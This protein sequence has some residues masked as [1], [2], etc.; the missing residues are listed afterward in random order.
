MKRELLIVGL[1]F[2]FLVSSLSGCFEQKDDGGTTDQNGEASFTYKGENARFGFLGVYPDYKNEFDYEEMAKI[3]VGWIRVIWGDS[4]FVWGNIEKT[5]GT[6]DFSL[7]DEFVKEMQNYGFNIF[8]VIWPYAQWDQQNCYNESCLVNENDVFI[9]RLGISRCK[10]CNE[11]AYLNFI[12]TMVERYDDDDI[13][14]MPGLKYPIKYYEFLNEPTL[15]ID[16]EEKKDATEMHF[17]GTS[18]EFVEFMNITYDAMKEVYPDVKIV[19]AGINSLED[20]YLTLDFWKVVYEKHS[21]FDIANVHSI[22]QGNYD[23]FTSAFR[24]LLVDYYDVVPTL[25]VGE[26]EIGAHDVVYNEDKQAA[27]L[28]K[29]YVRAFANG[30]EKIIY[31]IWYDP[32][33]S[34]DFKRAAVIR[35]DRTE[36]TLY[37]AFKTMISKIDYFTSIEKIDKDVY[38][39]VV[40]ESSVYVLWDGASIPDEIIGQVRVTDIYGIEKIMDA[41]EVELFENPIFIEI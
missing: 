4:S 13:D 23:L 24:D 6:Y 31:N 10:P 7:Q 19:H 3:G 37:Y 20:D 21:K 28:I 15:N 1:S 32:G 25:W 33:S 14:D 2:L 41:S 29:G 12:K 9:D 35:V 27:D 22:N 18:G 30:A 40:N 17:K 34:E 16:V 11:T 36:K 39:F 5:G 8:P 38:R 26:V